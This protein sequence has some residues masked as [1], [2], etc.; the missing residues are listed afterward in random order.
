MRPTILTV[1]ENVSS[2]FAV[3]ARGN[4]AYGMTHTVSSVLAT[5]SMKSARAEMPGRIDGP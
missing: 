3:L 1:I 2:F 4:V 5:A